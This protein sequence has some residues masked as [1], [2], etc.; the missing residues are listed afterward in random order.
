MNNDS[1]TL[2]QLGFIGTLVKERQVPSDLK[3]IV[4]GFYTST[5]SK[6]Q[7]SDTINA[8]L[9]LPKAPRPENLGFKP[10]IADPKLAEKQALLAALPASRYAL[11][12]E[13]IELGAPG[14]RMNGNDLLFV[15]VH[16]HRRTKSR[17]LFR[18]HGAPGRFS[19]SY[20]GNI[21]EQLLV[22]RTL[23]EAPNFHARLFADHYRV[24][25]RCSAELTD[26][27][28]RRLGLGPTCKGYFG[29]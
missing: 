6:R 1:A 10:V 8:L 23:A 25:A 22:L 7:A 29:L 2:K 9:R 3:T 12:A 26:V 5:P 15:E 14:I 13:Q 11:K 18:V 16:E 20:I 4:E 24:C 28:S 19:R 27:E 21:D 17:R